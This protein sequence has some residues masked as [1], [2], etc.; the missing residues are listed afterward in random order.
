MKE[1]HMKIA[2][3]GSVSVL[4]IACLSLFLL[5]FQLGR[6]IK[7]LDKAKEKELNIK[8]AKER[9]LICKDIEAK[10]ATEIASYNE[11]AKK[12]ESQKNLVKELENKAKTQIS[13]THPAKKLK[14]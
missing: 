4:T 1:N 6:E 9:E 5:N 13:T 7:Y 10:H 3:L 12:L 2:M 11:L 8:I 14:K